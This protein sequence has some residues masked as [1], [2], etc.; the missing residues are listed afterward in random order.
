MKVPLEVEKILQSRDTPTFEEI[1]IV[2]DWARG[3]PKVMHIRIFGDWAI[4]NHK[5]VLDVWQ[6]K[7]KRNASGQSNAVRD[8]A[9]DIQSS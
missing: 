8:Q 4:R 9:E 3:N 2:A 5:L 1:D 7:E 6:P